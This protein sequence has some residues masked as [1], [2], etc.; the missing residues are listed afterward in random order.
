MKKSLK[1]TGISLLIII[2]IIAVIPFAFQSQ[3]KDMVKTVINKNINAKVDFSNVSLS[4]LSSFPKA[5]VNVSDL[6]ITNFEPF[7][8]E[9]FATVKSMSFTMSIKELF[10]GEDEP[11]IVNSIIAN[12]ALIILKTDALGNNNY[13]I[14]KETK[15]VNTSTPENNNFS[16]DIEAYS[17]N[18]SAFTFIDNT[19]NTTLYIT[20]LDHAGKGVFSADKSELDTNT[21]AKVSFAIDST[22]YLNNTN[23]K[24]DALIGL[25]LSTNTY[26]F[27]DN[28]GYINDLP[29]EFQ[30]YVKQLENGQEID[31]TF[32]N[33]ESSFKDFLA[34]IPTAYSKNL[35]AI[36][37]TGDFKVHGIIKGISSDKTIPNLDINIIS[38]NASFKYPDLPKR[39][40]NITI[41]TSIRNTTGHVDD[42][43]IDI[44]TLNFKI[45]DDVFKSSATLKNLTKNMLVNA[46]IDGTLNL[47]H[48][49][50]AYPI[51]LDKSLSGILK[52][53]LNTAF[54]M[55][56]IETNAYQRINNNGW[57]SVSDFIFSSED[58]VNP[59]NIY[60]ADI[61]FNPKTITL[62]NFNAKTGESDFKAV[63]T[64]ENL[65][66]FLLSDKN[67][68]GNFNVSSNNF[69]V[70]DFMVE[71]TSASKN[72]KTT[73]ET[74]SLK[75]PAFLDCTFNVNAKNVI[76]DDLNLKDVKGILILKDQKATLKNMTSR[77]FDGSLAV[78]GTV[79]T[80]TELPTFK[81][82]LGAEGFD[83]SKSFN[84]LALLQNLA[85]IAK[86]IQGKLNTT[87]DL[88]GTLDKELSPN[89]SSISGNALA[90]ILSSKI[91]PQ[92]AEV[93][94]K[95]TNSLNFIDFNKLDLKDLKTQFEFADGNVSVKP[96]S[97][98]Y[99]DIDIDISGSHN[100]DQAISYKAI[101]NVPA[102]YLG[103][104][105]T[106]LIGNINAED[107]NKIIIPVTANITGS[108]SNPTVNTDL[109]SA[110]SNVS[111][112]LIATQKQKL[113]NQGKN[114]V[115]GL[116]SELIGEKS[117]KI[118]STKSDSIATK[119]PI[120]KNVK[121][122]LGGLLGGNKKKKDT[123][124]N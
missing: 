6:E 123:I 28:K 15:N 109:T 20:E 110:V 87:I 75:I 61:T 13:D 36:T 52:A 103:R 107:A 106:Q 102:K 114:N 80:Q 19:A 11:I 68:Q 81:L 111:K 4:F 89:L 22:T 7:K 32:Q 94:G 47:G 115:K 96:F 34:V 59:I 1:I 17:I 26:T 31:I 117:T 40:E 30:G 58:I 9:T 113:L 64:I 38:N 85:P 99:D 69:V 66:G 63:G 124:Q 108:F 79:S 105:V 104:E 74:E 120:T 33:P 97:I 90:E 27:K 100:I 122:I 50:K 29:L 65:L 8:D 35:D 76:Y 45:D 42:T 92:K 82:N 83:I 60:K 25:D 86:V 70:S 91:N 48:I 95:L 44:K 12:E 21:Q 2:V 112:Q 10:K 37:T 55:N 3:L 118:D 51:K 49:T 54:D 98:K 84:S 41:N 53:K 62:N 46:N 43:Y 121:S 73:S 72:N 67:L 5:Q 93:L 77:L 56:A 23:L 116:L 57:L 24:L 119:D 16:F 101:F 88:S 71:D 14:A 18:N 78:N 39:V